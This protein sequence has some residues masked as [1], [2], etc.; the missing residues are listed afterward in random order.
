[1][2]ES[3]SKG[4]VEALVRTPAIFGPGVRSVELLETHISW[5]LLA[6]TD[7]YKIKKPVNFGFLDFSTLERRRR[8]CEEE[9]RLNGRLAPELY[10]EVVPITGTSEAPRL[11]GTGSAIE[12]AVRMRRFPQERLLSRVLQD[13][14]L[15]TTDIDRLAA[16]VAD[17]HARI[18]T[19]PQ[20]APF[21]APREVMKPVEE[22]FRQLAVAEDMDPALVAEIAQLETWCRSEYSRRTADFLARKEAGFVRECHGDMHLGNMVLRDD[23]SVLIFDG[24]EF[25]EPL[26]WIDVASE[27]A[28]VTMDLE[29][30]GRPDFAHRFLNQYLEL[31][32]DYGLLSVLTFYQVYRAMVRAK[33]ACLRLAQPG[34]NESERSRN[35]A[36][37]RSYVKLGASLT[38]PPQPFLL[39]VH[40][41]SGSG[42]T[43]GTQPVLEELGA[44]RLRSDVERKRL[45]GLKSLDRSRSGLGTDLYSTE[46]TSRTYERLLDR[47]RSI[48]CSG[49]CVIVD[50]TFLRR[51][52]RD[53]FRRLA[54]EL[55]TP[56]LIL[57][58]EA[59]VDVLRQ[60]IERRARAGGDASEA[61]VAV[62]EQQLTQREPLDDEERAHAI[63][64]ETTAPLDAPR[65]LDAIRSRVQP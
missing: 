33:V 58:F 10:L 57:D 40:G 23:R 24:I 35:L 8:F 62:L 25:S 59:P 18:A 44:V 41:L 49:R 37:F 21:G 48:L 42:K 30:R 12:Y 3:S 43:T 45:S 26:R 46:A 51:S 16:E 13:G 61:T 29:D 63:L 32:G 15:T 2:S 53:E 60:R 65:L 19:A 6:G 14:Q 36:E 34:M 52:D 55:R 31:T 28:F 39:L 17:F 27:I 64:V 9:L 47:A 5:V 22:N 20:D 54:V 50:A 56:W 4:L 38:R 1:M 11:G 7:A